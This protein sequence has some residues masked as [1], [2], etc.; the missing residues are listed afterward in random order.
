MSSFLFSFRFFLCQ[1][2]SATVQWCCKQCAYVMLSVSRASAKNKRNLSTHVTLQ[3][4]GECLNC[5]WFTIF[6]LHSL[7]LFHTSLL[8]TISNTYMHNVLT[9]GRRAPRLSLH[10][11][12]YNLA[13]FR[14]CR[15][16]NHDHFIVMIWEIELVIMTSTRLRLILKQCHT[17]KFPRATIDTHTGK[18]I[19]APKQWRMKKADFEGKHLCSCLWCWRIPRKAHSENSS[20]TPRSL[21][22][23]A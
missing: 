23:W 16:Q 5:F 10:K 17:C 2:Y 14:I 7:V 9:S 21:T 15:D 3:H 20:I 12:I 6:F 11:L 13:Q 1:Q 18:Q 4:H 8:D 22:K 19:C